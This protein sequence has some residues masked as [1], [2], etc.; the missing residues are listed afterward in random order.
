MN[1]F[2]VLIEEVRC[3]KIEVLAHNEAEAI[4]YVESEYYEKES[5]TLTDNDFYGEHRIFIDKEE[6]KPS[7]WLAAYETT[8]LR[9]IEVAE[10]HLFKLDNGTEEEF[11]EDELYRCIEA[12]QS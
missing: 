10:N 5:I 7:E 9:Q 11:K 8:C 4:K 2:E 12:N 1:P 6:E 3:K